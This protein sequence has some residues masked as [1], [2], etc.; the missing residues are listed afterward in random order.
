MLIGQPEACIYLGVSKPTLLKL[1]KKGLPVIK[2]D[3]QH[4]KIDTKDLD[5]WLKKHSKQ[6]G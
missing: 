4:P 2:V 1:I 5:E 6:E 3:G